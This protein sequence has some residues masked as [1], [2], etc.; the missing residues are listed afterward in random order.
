MADDTLYFS[1]GPV[2]IKQVIRYTDYKQFK[3]KVRIVSAEAVDQPE[4][5]A[6]SNP[7]KK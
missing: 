7:P 6:P 4:S 5:G 1:S 3:A 2:P